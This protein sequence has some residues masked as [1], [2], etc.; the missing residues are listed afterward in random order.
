VVRGT[1][2]QLNA[3]GIPVELTEI[4]NH[5]HWYYDLAPKINREVWDFLKKNEL[6]TDPKYHEYQFQGKSKR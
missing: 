1:R 3:H 4:P 2:D 5:N 6:S